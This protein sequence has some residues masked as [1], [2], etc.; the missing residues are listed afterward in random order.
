M[1]LENQ[2]D[3]R[4]F[5]QSKGF[6]RDSLASASFF[7]FPRG[8]HLNLIKSWEKNV[9]PSLE[10]FNYLCHLLDISP[11]TLFKLLKRSAP[12]FKCFRYGRGV[13]I[14]HIAESG[15]GI[16]SEEI[17]G[18]D[19]GAKPQYAKLVKKLAAFFEISTEEMQAVFDSGEES[20]IDGGG[21]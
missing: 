3:F 10:N 18:L 20:V 16:T 15:L 14:K 17:R 9:L 4:D 5:Y 6:T 1:T 19:Y 11:A 8:F 21:L 2:S 7:I 12:P 13:K